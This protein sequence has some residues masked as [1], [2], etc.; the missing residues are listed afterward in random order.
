MTERQPENGSGAADIQRGKLAGRAG[1]LTGMASG[2]GRAGAELFAREGAAIVAMDVDAAAG[3]KT[4]LLTV[5]V[6][7]SSSRVP[8]NTP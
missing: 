6:A 5:M 1:L 3:E 2:I 4:T 8:F 7:T